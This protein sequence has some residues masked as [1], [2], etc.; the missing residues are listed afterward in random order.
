MSGWLNE[1]TPYEGEPRSSTGWRLAKAG[2]RLVRSNRTALLLVLALAALWTAAAVASLTAGVRT[3]P[4]EEGSLS[5]LIADAV[6]LLATTYLLAAI[7][8]VADAAIDGVPLQPR[9]ALA[10]AG[11]RQRSLIGWA[12]L[13]LAVWAAVIL[14]F[15]ALEAN[16]LPLTLTLAWYVAGLFAIPF[17]LLAGDN[18]LEALR[19]SLGLLRRR[20]RVIVAALL[21]IFAFTC[22]AL[23]PVGAIV[24]HAAALNRE[25]E[26]TQEALVLAGVFVGMIVVA[27]S[28]ATRESFA[29]MLLRESIDDLPGPP[30][31]GRLRTRAK[32]LRFCGGTLAVFA[33]LAA[34]GAATQHDREVLD[35][36]RAPGATYTTLVPGDAGFD[37][38]LGTPVLYE[39]REIGTVLGSRPEGVH[40]SVTFHVDPGYSPSST[41][42]SFDV[43]ESNGSLSLVLE[44]STGAPGS[45]GYY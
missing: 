23:F 32:V 7:A 27:A 37:L 6:L 19:G 33:A 38:P 24:N 11:E 39:G 28:F 22:I 3:T 44:P 4:E 35:T 8:A 45:E 31:A 12:L 15:R 18:P 42:G 41:P 36:S 20:W 2:W 34:L 10:E 13:T 43:E 14:A 30:F 21:G 29:V 16:G 25:G 40:L 9:E 1:L 26:G 5:W 17:I